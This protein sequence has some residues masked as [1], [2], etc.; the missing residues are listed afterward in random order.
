MLLPMEQFY[1]FEAARAHHCLLYMEEKIEVVRHRMHECGIPFPSK[2][3]LALLCTLSYA[4][5]AS[6]ELA[7][8]RRAVKDKT[9]DFDEPSVD[10]M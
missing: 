1:H 6:P 2:M 5:C 3:P 9:L 8:T 4:N 7:A 10:S